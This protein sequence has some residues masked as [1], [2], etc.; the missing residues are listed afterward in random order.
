MV[1]HSLR[2]ASGGATPTF[3]VFEEKSKEGVNQMTGPAGLKSR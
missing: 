2:V 1:V 3:D